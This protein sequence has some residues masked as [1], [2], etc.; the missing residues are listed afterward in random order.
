MPDCQQV[1]IIIKDVATIV[2]LGIASVVAICG[3][4]TWK[5]QM[6]GIAN[7]KLARRLL[8]AVY[9]FR[10]SLNI[11][12]NPLFLASEKNIALQEV[13]SDVKPSEELFDYES[14][15]AVYQVRWKSVT[16]AFDNLSAVSL[17]AE[18]TWGPYATVEL[19][20][21][22]QK[23]QELEVALW[24]ILQDLNPR[25]L[26]LLDTVSRITF[27]QKVYASPN[28]D[29]ED[30]YLKELNSSITKLEKR[31]KPYLANKK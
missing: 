6:K 29:I 4:T 26:P 15:R 2:S 19:G 10:N 12:R 23:K 17:E 1:L 16:D 22:T 5:R 27:E 21:I 20:E 13:H 25:S 11:V 24:M 7:Y 18:A 28:P 8:M 3:L 9:K 31:L 30:S 14:K